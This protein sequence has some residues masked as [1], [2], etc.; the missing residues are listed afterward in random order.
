MG[1]FCWLILGCN[2]DCSLYLIAFVQIK[3]L[4]T[5]LLVAIGKKLGNMAKIGRNLKIYLIFG[6]F[7]RYILIVEIPVL[8]RNIWAIYVAF[9]SLLIGHMAIYL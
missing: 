8:R 6:G 2:N 4:F 3:V 9:L 5:I 1:F 7:L